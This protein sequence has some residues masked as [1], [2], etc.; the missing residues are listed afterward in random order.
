MTPANILEPLAD[1]LYIS[2]KLYEGYHLRDLLF[3]KKLDLQVGK[4]KGV[5]PRIPLVEILMI[6]NQG[7]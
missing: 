3:G 5:S 4:L 7:Y 2:H 6:T 1:E